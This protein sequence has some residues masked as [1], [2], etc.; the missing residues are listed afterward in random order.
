MPIGSSQLMTM[1]IQALRASRPK[2]DWYFR[3]LR[4][5]LSRALLLGLASGGAVAIVTLL[6]RQESGPA[7]V[8]GATILLSLCSAC[9]VGLTVPTLL[10]A[11]RLDPKIAAGPA[12]LALTDV[13]TLLFYL[14]LASLSL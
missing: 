12:T 8:L 10:Y 4:R 11:R 6:W 7:L 2:L 9:L 1:T 3:T 5:E 14:I 13:L